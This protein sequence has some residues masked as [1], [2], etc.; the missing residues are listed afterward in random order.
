MTSFR[1]YAYIDA[2][3]KGFQIGHN[4][5]D[6]YITRDGVYVGNVENLAQFAAVL[7]QDWR[8]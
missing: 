6:Y 1:V 7:F 4:G 2:C 8:N 3:W 5:V